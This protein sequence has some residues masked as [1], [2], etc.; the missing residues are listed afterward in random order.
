MRQWTTAC[1]DW[2]QR[3]VNRQ[4][5]IPQGPIFPEQAELGLRVFKELVLVDVPGQPKIGAVTRQWVYDFVGALFGAYDAASGQRLIQEFFLLISKKN[6][7]ST[8]SAGIMLT[9]LI[10]NWRHDAE[11]FIIAPT[12]EVAN[13]SFR[14]AKAM[15][16]ADAELSD[17]F[18]V[19]GHTQLRCNTVTVVISVSTEISQLAQA[20][21]AAAK[22]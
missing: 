3:L 13:N 7:K 17:I 1:P 19:S 18:N 11:F 22:V 8:I 21:H 10:L 16:Q 15:I 9:A 12:V 20:N 6:G 2:Q 14:P 4:T 5:L